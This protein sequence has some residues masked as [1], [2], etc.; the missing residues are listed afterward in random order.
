MKLILI[1]YVNRTGSTFLSNEFS[2]YDSILVCPESEVLVT[3]FIASEKP[4]YNQPKKLFHLLR[5][6]IETDPK[7]K[8]WNLNISDFSNLNSFNNNFEIFLAILI[9]YRNQIKPYAK[10]IVFK[11]D[12]LAYYF[13]KIHSFYLERYKIKFISIFRDGRAAYASQRITIGAKTQKPMNKN[14]VKAAKIWKNWI[15]ICLIHNTSPHFIIIRY[16]SLITD[17]QHE[18]DNLLHKLQMDVEIVKKNK[19]GD[20]YERIPPNQRS[21]HINILKPPLKNHID[22]WIN[23]LPANHIV[24]FEK[25]AKDELILLNHK[26]IK[27]H[28]NKTRLFLL[29]FIY[30]LEYLYLSSAFRKWFR[31][32]KGLLPISWRSRI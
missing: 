3:Y 27:P 1:S 18:F 8:Y 25:I 31:K 32:I 26:L 30:W 9:T 6:I 11:A 21:M 17:F 16:E 29:Y 19:H 14:P 28:V 7:L 23:E 20:L 12:T 4:Y 2:K 22:K 24:I 13:D 5:Q 15:N 10:T